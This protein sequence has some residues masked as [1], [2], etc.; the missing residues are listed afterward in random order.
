MVSIW[1]LLRCRVLAVA[2]ILERLSAVK[3]LRA[4]PKG[5][6]QTPEASSLPATTAS[7]TAP[8]TRPPA[9]TTR[10]P[11]HPPTSHGPEPSPGSPSPSQAPTR[12]NRS[13]APSPTLPPTPPTDSRQ[14]CNAP[15]QSS[16]LLVAV[17]L[18]PSIAVHRGR[19]RPEIA[20]SPL[21]R[22]S[23]QDADHS[24]DVLAHG[25]VLN[26]EADFQLHAVPAHDPSS[27]LRRTSISTRR[28]IASSRW[29]LRLLSSRRPSPILSERLCGFS[30]SSL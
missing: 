4:V 19:R 13:P 22:R 24:L 28:R 12:R 17:L 25:T 11:Q 10:S 9:H 6:H 3:P 2:T 16:L 7:A 30:A 1:L 20:D 27:S 23:L 14:P 21:V 18:E 29:Y 15:H 26:P 8:A 5:L